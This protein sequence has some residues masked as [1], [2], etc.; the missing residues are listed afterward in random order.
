[1][2]AAVCLLALAVVGLAQTGCSTFGI[3]PPRYKLLPESEAFRNGAVPPPVLA[4]ELAKTPV[5][6]YILEPGDALLIQ[7]VDFDSP[8]RI[9]ADQPILP[10]GTIELGVYGRPVVAGMTVPQVETQVAQLVK[11]KEG[12]DHALTVRLVGRTKVFYVLGEVNSP[13]SFPLSGRETVLDGLMAAGGLTRAAQEKKIILVRPSHPDNCREVLPVCYPQIVQ[14]G[15]THTNYQLRPGD[16]IY[17]PSQ[18]MLE[19]L[20]PSQTKTT[21][22]CCKPH[23]P[24]YQGG[25]GGC[26]TPAATPLTAHTPPPVTGSVGSF[27]GQ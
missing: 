11:A 22:P 18:G 25:A 21:A 15:D 16:R 4:R 2:R 5:A 23:M 17:V 12:K 10:D 24:C 13:G 9:A 8:V 20:F 14:L 27:V 7:P 19:S 1:M 3:S 26:V 6:E